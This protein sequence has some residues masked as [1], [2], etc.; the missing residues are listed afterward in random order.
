MKTTTYL[1]RMLFVALFSL[2]LTAC[3]GES[4]LDAGEVLLT[5]DVPMV[6]DATGTTCVEPEPIQ[7]PAPTVPDALNENCVVGVDPNAPLPIYFPAEN[8]AVVYYNRAALGATNE[9]DDP[10]YE[11]YRLHT[12][13]SDFCD[14][15]AAPHDTT[16]WANGHV[17][18]GVD[19]TYGAYWILNLKDGYGEC[20]NFIIHIG[21]DDAGKALGSGDFQM[22]L[23]QDDPDYAR[24]N[25]TFDGVPSVFEY[26]V[27]SL[28]K[29]P[30]SVKDAAAH[31]IDANTFVWFIDNPL[32]DTVTDV[33][34]HHSMTAGI[35]ADENDVF[36]G[37]KIA[38]VPAEL[39]DEQKAA[40]PKVSDW[41]A[42]QLDVSAEQAKSLLKSQLVVV[43]ANADGE[44][45][46][47]SAVQ[48]D[49]VLDALYTAGEADADEATLGVS[50]NNNMI[51][52]ALW[53]PTAQSVT[54]KVFDASKAEVASHAMTES[55]D[56][57]IWSYAADVSMD[58]MF[59]QYEIVLF[60]PQ[61][62]QIE[63][64]TVTDPYSVSLSTNGMY[65]Q[66]VNLSDADLQPDGW[67][68]H[69]VPAGS[70]PEDAVIYEGHI[71]DF[72]VLDESTSEAN[73]GKYLAFTEM[74]SAPVQHL[75][76]L[77]DSGL[78]HF[79]MLPANDLASVNE[80]DEDKVDLHDTVADLCAVKADAP[81]CGVED[82]NATILSVL[83]G[84]STYTDDAAKL[85]DALRGY[86]SF[87]WGYDPK[88]FN[89]PDGS[90]ASDA[91]GVARIVEMRAMVQALHEV[92]LRVV[93]DVVYNHTNSAGLWD[94]SVFDKVVP[95]YYH[96]RDVVSGA[97]IQDTCCNDTALEHRMM[98]KFMV[99]SLVLWTEQY[100]FDGFR[101]DIMS[102]GSKEQMLAARDAVQAVDADNYF[103][104]EGWGRANRGFEHA[105]QFNMAGTEIST[106]N[107][108]L[109]D[110]IR[111]GELF[112]GID[113][114]DGPFIK[115]DIIKF[116][117]AG[118]LADYVLTSFK[119]TPTL[120]SAYNQSMYAK[121]PADV[122]NYI[123]KH[124]NETLWDQ[125]QLKLPY[126]ISLE[127]RV[128]IQNLSQSIILLSQGVP[129][130]QLGG[131]ML[132]SKSLDRNTYDAGDWFNKVDFTY[133]SNNFNIG[134][135]LER[136]ETAP[137][138][139]EK[140]DEDTLVAT[141][142]NPSAQAG[143]N[144]I[145]FAS[146]VFNE[147]LQIRTTSKLFRLATAQDVIDRVGFHNIGKRQT[148]GLIVMS[149]DDGTGLEDLDPTV[150]AIV[151]V[152][153]GSANELS[154]TVATAA[155][156]SLHPVQ[157]ASVDSS[158]ASA[159]FTDGEGEG[160]FTVPAFTTAV[161]VLPQ[162]EAQGT[163]LLATATSGAPDVVPYGDT[164]PF[165]K[166]EMNGWADVDQMTYK[167]SGIY[168]VAL[169]LSAGSYSFK[170]ASEDWSTI[171]LGAP[172]AADNM[173][174]EGEDFTL[175]PGSND[176]LSITIAADATYIFSLDASNT[177]S[178]VLNV[179]N[180]NPFFGN[181]V[182]LRGDMNG[183]GESDAMTYLGEGRF[184]VTTTIEAGEKNFK[185]ASADWS[186]V[187]L[188]AP[189]DD[190]EVL[191]GEEQLVVAGSNDNFYMN[192]DDGEYTFILDASNIEEPIL[193]VYNAEMF[194]ATTVFIRGGMNGWGEVDALTYHGASQ[195][196]V[197]IALDAQS[198]EFKVASG[199]W[200]TFNLGAT[201]AEDAEVVV[202]VEEA[203][204]QDSQTNFTMTI[205][206][207]G[208]YVFTVT[209]PDP[210]N[211]TLAVTKAN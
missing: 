48:A 22:P 206:E 149:I 170:V 177:E 105:D 162:G 4:D 143:F 66:F 10:S 111:T 77:A 201:S 187:N 152:V 137:F 197:T 56:T 11:G 138:S 202:D 16:D 181:T 72:S 73:R 94:N 55:S 144:E 161:F 101:F 78:T 29:Q 108:R 102:H 113:F 148:Q 35:E 97:V 14:A 52:V 91:D 46:A 175:L 168:E 95:G 75:Q 139:G 114:E 106:F 127:N 54:L 125:L 86:D 33:A 12:W 47:A 178:P 171:N 5:C 82:D 2:F 128:R 80:S 74:D 83:E 36:N 151:V 135:P 129:F 189:A 6:P 195:Y 198:Y 140:I 43:G 64:V 209:G 42:Y 70:A 183:W 107:D 117:L 192:F 45:I 150:D 24:M 38:L 211:L 65:S 96:S 131:D 71:R 68:D 185:L 200:S 142:S 69:T 1:A 155:G 99:D 153:N 133:Q 199:D 188:G 174:V 190:K 146:N 176:N 79:H 165:V 154:H 67:V 124:D 122:V 39:T 100:K 184:S 186:T 81:V 3:G 136:P 41:P 85:V 57:G 156:F 93:L 210:L 63:T 141:L 115:Q 61:N 7:C 109:R 90:Y 37:S 76:K 84:Y 110:G 53:A 18:D 98:D 112:S 21:T 118:S 163:G 26:P 191:P 194:G 30:V 160:T 50:Y 103:Y 121:D 13:N 87:N 88:H 167:G 196:S 169:T 19:P 123:S 173:V 20:G 147:F 28:G 23:Q 158:V 145:E 126:D 17:H 116:G 166:G 59:Y 207:A 179:R 208:D 44:T 164:F 58:R 120:G 32:A 205:E 49:L 27:V 204:V 180:E 15:Y 34:L 172:S 193:T 60:H 31:W 203:L 159:S 9:S 157:Q 40:A 134:L 104:G 8:E 62:A 92:G 182:L 119:G 89:V 51:D 130:F 132:R 25:F